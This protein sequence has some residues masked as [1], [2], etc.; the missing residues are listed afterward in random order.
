MDGCQ[1]EAWILRSSRGRI[2]EPRRVLGDSSVDNELAQSSTKPQAKISSTRV[3]SRKCDPVTTV[4]EG[5]ETGGTQVQHWPVRLA[6]M[7]SSM[8]S[9]KTVSEN[10]MAQ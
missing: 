4:L 7:A 10:I 9:E 6:K 3:K 1:E 2:E 8:F 5:A